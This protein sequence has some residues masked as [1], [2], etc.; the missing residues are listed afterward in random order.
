M[1]YPNAAPIGYL[2][3]TF[4]KISETHVLNEILELERQGL[5]VHIF[6][7][8]RP[9][10][11]EV[12]PAI[13]EV[14]SPVTYIPSLLPKFS[15]D[16]AVELLQPQNIL[17][18]QS[19]RRYWQTSAFQQS[20]PEA[21]VLNELL[22][23]GYLALELQKLG[24][25]HLHACSADVPAAVAELVQSLIGISYS[26]TAHVKDIYST[27]PEVFDRRMDKAEFVLACTR[28][29]QQFLQG[30]SAHHSSIYLSY[31]GIDLSRFPAESKPVTDEA[32]RVP[33]LLSVIH[34]CEEDGLTDLLQACQ[35]LKKKRYAFRCKVVSYGLV[36]FEIKRLIQSLQLEDVV[37]LVSN[38]LHDELIDL[39]Q[40]ADVF[41]LPCQTAK[42]GNCSDIPQALLEA[43]AMKLPVIAANTPEI[44]ELVEHMRNGLLVLQQAPLLLAAEL[45]YLLA[46]P[47]LMQELGCAAREQV[48]QQFSLTH[49]T[50]QTR[51]LLLSAVSCTPAKVTS[52]QA[53][54]VTV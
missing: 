21:K 41:V 28:H 4:P 54:K 34:S 12:Y 22:Q 17:L 1:Y 13:A 44:E 25:T 35:L 51:D 27:E 46:Q 38:P 2:L 8:R 53:V 23:A 48:T 6:S 33:L 20:R 50:Q 10:D 42:N 29:N 43:M 52:S 40:Q 18:E 36:Q 37:S 26:F 16:A 49:N 32:S 30:I 45:E 7:L 11:E 47:D 31:P 15:S 39:Y 3:K 19:P 5:K 9:E 24:I 14:Q